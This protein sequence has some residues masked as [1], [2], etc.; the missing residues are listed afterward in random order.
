MGTGPGTNGYQYPSAVAQTD[1]EVVRGLWTEC[2]EWFNAP[3]D[4]ERLARI[5]ERYM[6]PDVVYEEDPVWPD[7]GTYRGRDAVT[8]RFLEYADMLQIRSISSVDVV[9][10]GELVLAEV[11][12]E[13]LGTSSAETIDYVW[14]Y[15]V[16]VE[17]GLVKHFRAWYKPEE[18]HRAAGLTD[19]SA[20]GDAS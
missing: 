3:A 5:T 17:D 20:A 14:N 10:A 6:A 16:R 7:A 11:R 19:H 13:M 8:A 2:A 4:P 1:V 18:A 9:D 12:V 15:T